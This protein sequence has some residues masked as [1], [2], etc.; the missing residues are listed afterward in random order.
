MEAAR[1]DPEAQPR[2]VWILRG[3]KSG[4]FVQM[5]ALADALGWGYESKC[6]VF[7]RT[8]LV[9]HLWPRPTRAGL[10][11]D[12]SSALAPPWPDLVLTAG[13]RNELVARWIRKASPGTTRIV[14]IG[15]PW[16]RIET[17]DLV[18][19]TPQ[20]PLDAAPAVLINDLP[21]HDITADALAI[22]GG[23][24]SGVLQGARPRLAL[25]VGGDSGPFVFS[26]A[27]AD[28]LAARVNGLVRRSGARLWLSTSART[29]RAFA[30]RLVAALDRPE[31][32]WSWSRASG[33]ANPYRGYLALADGFVVTSES[34]SMTAEAL[35]TG[36]PVWLF[37]VSSR[38]R[39]PWWLHAESYRWKPLTHRLAQAFAP[40][41]L[42]RDV[43]NIH[44][45]LI[46]AERV[47]W[48]D[49]GAV[50]PASWHQVPVAPELERSVAA[51]RRL[52]G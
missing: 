22:A 8:E 2:R 32:S 14:H 41:R 12:A 7:R 50:F 15:R 11:L 17:F 44:A 33:S 9:Q 34:V 46:D 51:V 1:H 49:D 27:L 42:R 52:F 45:R 13:R 40:R 30:E 43:G 39:L 23:E 25:L 5:R 3:P 31:H 10:D 20:Y 38:S 18:I 16:S 6:L 28:R 29:P 47:M 36:K 4:D 21:L 48:L 19:S 26:S 35:A 24:W 37:D